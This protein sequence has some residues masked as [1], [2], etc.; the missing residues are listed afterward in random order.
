MIPDL[1]DSVAFHSYYSLEAT[2][3]SL[4]SDFALRAIQ[5]G[6]IDDDL[7]LHTQ[8]SLNKSDNR[9]GY[10]Q[11]FSLLA[12]QR[13]GQGPWYFLTHYR[14]HSLTEVSFSRTAFELAFTGNAS[15]V[16]HELPFHL[17]YRNVN[18]QSL[19][20]GL[21]YQRQSHRFGFSPGIV[22]S[23]Y[24]LEAGL[25]DATLYTSEDLSSMTLQTR[26]AVSWSDTT[27]QHQFG[28]GKGVNFDVYYGYH[29][30][31]QEFFISLENF[32][33]VS[34]DQLQLH[35][36]TDS[37]WH[38]DGVSLNLFETEDFRF[39]VNQDSL[40]QWTGL[41][42]PGSKR[43]MLPSHL[44][45]GFKQKAG[46]TF[47]L[48]LYGR[49]HFYSMAQPEIHVLSGW[50]FHPQW[51]VMLSIAHGGYGS[52]KSGTHIT[53]E[54]GNGFG[55]RF[56]SNNLAGMWINQNTAADFYISLYKF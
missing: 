48:G 5:G 1:K 17:E 46:E 34:F 28:A 9:L 50:R 56:G 45:I 33:I 7:K 31:K 35:D 55:L 19:Q 4:S 38:F 51:K 25:K 42:Q 32:G 30:S 29:T 47:E 24:F 22:S 12:G 54:L 49:Y 36:N 21:H 2:S 40:K 20:L 23:A 11:T 39:S 43:I 52:L 27:E 18:W 6:L 15:T 37:T 10:Q 14:H 41:R 53:A 3:N 26:A 13:I 44:T 16:G 8:N